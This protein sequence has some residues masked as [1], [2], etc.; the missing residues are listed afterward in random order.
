MTDGTVR[1]HLRGADPDRNFMD[2][3]AASIVGTETVPDEPVPVAATRP[4]AE[5]SPAIDTAALLSTSGAAHNVNAALL[6]SVVKAESGGNPRAVSRTG[7]RG[8]MQLMPGTAAELGVADSFSP[9][10]NV[11]GGSAYLDRL[12]TR[13][14]DNLPLALAAYNAG[15]AAVDRYHGIPPYRETRA[16]VARVIRE[17]NRRVLQEEKLA[18]TTGRHVLSAGVVASSAGTGR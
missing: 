3:P 2:V 7:A 18:A 16:Y 4:A 9:E 15:P 11:D 1:L 5:A 13:Y 8:L 12:L 14:H 10:G 17:F 6:A